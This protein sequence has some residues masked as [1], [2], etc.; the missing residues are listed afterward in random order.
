[1]HQL[2][3]FISSSIITRFV[4]MGFS[5][6]RAIK[7]L[8]LKALNPDLAMDW[9]LEHSD[10][11]DIDEPLSRSQLL[12]LAR[13]FGVLTLPNLSPEVRNAIAQNMCT[14]TVTRREYVSQQYYFCHTCRLAESKGVCVSCLNR[15]HAGHQVSSRPINSSQFYCDCGAGEG[16]SPCQALVADPT[17]TT[18]SETID[19]ERG[20]EDEKSIL[21]ADGQKVHLRMDES[22]MGSYSSSI[23]EPLILTPGNP[24]EFVN[25]ICYF[26]ID[27][28]PQSYITSL[29]LAQYEN[30]DL[31]P[32]YNILSVWQ[33]E[34]TTDNHI[35]I[36]SP[37]SIALT[38]SSDFVKTIL[39]YFE[40]NSS[41]PHILPIVCIIILHPN[42]LQV[43]CPTPELINR[44][45]D[46]LLN[47]GDRCRG[48][49]LFWVITF[50][51]NLYSLPSCTPFLQ[52]YPKKIISMLANISII[53][54]EP[55]V[56]VR[57]S[58]LL[59]NLA[60]RLRPKLGD[61]IIGDGDL[62]LIVQVLMKL[63]ENYRTMPIGVIRVSIAALVAIF[64]SHLKASRSQNFLLQEQAALLQI[65]E[66][67]LSLKETEVCSLGNLLL[68][69][70]PSQILLHRT[71][72]VY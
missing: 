33:L 47:I 3:S 29:Q 70:L 45:F 8:L 11:S 9:L 7:A 68:E 20:T 28:L 22:M 72:L 52:H 25:R 49:H 23:K 40:T 71:N 6:S 26:Q 41:L 16:T 65:I 4:E 64:S 43:L 27:L 17:L 51:V 2:R 60:L 38:P 48:A 63:L 42:N 24:L 30:L 18:S 69:F 39:G 54:N 67:W 61:Q 35:P 37:A 66:P 50:F 46:H 10:D 1:M 59:S 36:P 15:C 14:F 19:G 57:F 34:S 21:N 32:L 58:E 56:Q 62:Q 5:E 53:D 12:T 31:Q 13:E 55:A 44:F